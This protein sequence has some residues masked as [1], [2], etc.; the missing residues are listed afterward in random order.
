[1]IRLLFKFLVFFLILNSCKKDPSTKINFHYDYFPLT[2]GS[3]IIYDADSVVY[4]DF[5]ETIDTFSYQIK[6]V[7]D[8]HFV[9][10]EGDTAFVL[11]VYKRLADTLSWQSYKTWSVNVSAGKAEKVEDNLRFIKLVFPVSENKTWEG[12]SFFNPDQDE[13]ECY[14]DWDYQYKNLHEKNDSLGNS[15]DSTITVLQVDEQPLTNKDFSMEIYAKKV[16]LIY[17]KHLCLEKGG[18]LSPDAPYVKGFIYTLKINS[19]SN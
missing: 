16:G 1:M 7:V 4:D 12:N 13:L 10:L 9:D 18:D 5:K 19:Y 3:W 17:K 15:F 8:T 14:D 6:E 11:F 2:E